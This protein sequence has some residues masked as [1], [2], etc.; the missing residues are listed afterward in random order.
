[1]E[2][3]YEDQ[4]D[5]DVRDLVEQLERESETIIAVEID[6]SRVRDCRHGTG[7][8]ASK[9]NTHGARIL[10]PSRN[11]FPSDSVLHEL[12]HIR[13]FLLERVPKIVQC[14]DY[15]NWDY[16]ISDSLTHLDNGIEHMVIVPEEIR[17]KPEREEY[18]ESVLRR[19]LEDVKDVSLTEDERD[20]TLM[21]ARVFICHVLTNAE[22][23]AEADELI[24]S[25]G[26]TN[27]A[28]QLFE[29]L[30]PSLGSKENTVK[31]YF[32]NLPPPDGLICLE[33]IENINHSTRV[34]PLADL[35]NC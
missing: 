12:L 29:A 2:S 8:L 18:W 23:T 19:V 4:L 25:F 17:R 3:N 13:R 28:S 15:H 24:E 33:Y 26:I 11:H 6:S 31:A 5:D 27:R 1:M 7:P 20:R 32:E 16:R 22:L 34:V 9:V 14:D 30:V 21:L 10:I 35:I